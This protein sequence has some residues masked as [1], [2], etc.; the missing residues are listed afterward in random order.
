[1][2]SENTD[3]EVRSTSK[4]SFAGEI[5]NQGT[6][7]FQKQAHIGFIDPVTFTEV[8]PRDGHSTEIVQG[9]GFAEIRVTRAA[10]PGWKFNGWKNDVWIESDDRMLSSKYEFRIGDDR[11]ILDLRDPDNYPWTTVDGG[12]TGVWLTDM[13][14]LPKDHF[15]DNP[16]TVRITADN[17]KTFW[18]YASGWFRNCCCI[19]QIDLGEDDAEVILA[20]K[21]IQAFVPKIN[22]FVDGVS[23]NDL[24][25][26]IVEGDVIDVKWSVRNTK[27]Q[28]ATQEISA[29]LLVDGVRQ[30]AFTWPNVNIAPDETRVFENDFDT[31]VYGPG[32]YRFVLSSEDF[33]YSQTV[34]VV[35]GEGPM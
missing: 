35:E 20:G 19:P 1:M 27:A 17:D 24:E 26:D 32:V 30:W 22:K 29:Y 9:G 3:I 13:L 5:D 14:G 28:S 8:D 4:L 12:I 6:V 2:W 34:V 33:S 23:V 31:D 18:L 7:K 11:Y 25:E 10:T 15:G 16:I 21:D